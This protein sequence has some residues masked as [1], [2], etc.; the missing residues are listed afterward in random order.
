MMKTN[1]CFDSGYCRIIIN[2]KKCLT[3]LMNVQPNLPKLF[4]VNKCNA[5]SLILA[6]DVTYEVSDLV[7]ES[8][9]SLR[10]RDKGG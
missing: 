9:R 1:R 3:S 2:C 10:F 6:S 7:P 8:L 4:V 5:I